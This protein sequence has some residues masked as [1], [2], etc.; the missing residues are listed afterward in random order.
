MFEVWGVSIYPIALI[1]AAVVNVAWGMLWY[2]PFFG[3]MWMELVGKK[4]EDMEMKPT[5]M[6]WSVVL[7]LVMATGLN[8]VLQFAQQ[9]SGVGD[10]LNIFVTPFMI[11]FTFILP[12]M[13]NL[14][15]WEG[16][17]VKLTV[18]N[19][20]HVLTTYMAMSAVL[21]IWI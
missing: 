8:S 13:M 16:K 2:G 12:S 20:T 14:V 4:S 1:I 17:K 11:A 18:L 9:V 19:F 10:I 21:L 3:K 7:A 15:I 6:V 5:D